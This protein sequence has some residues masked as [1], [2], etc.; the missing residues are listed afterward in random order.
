MGLLTIDLK[1][2]REN[3][4]TLKALADKGCEVGAVVKAESYGLGAAKVSDA[5]YKEGCRTFFIAKAHEIESL[6]DLPADT[7]VIVLN[8]YD[9]DYASLY[10]THQ[11]IPTLGSLY[12]VEAYQSHQDLKHKPCFL[13]FCTEMNRAGLDKDEREAILADPSVLEGLDLKGLMAHFACADEP[14]HPMTE[15]QYETYSAIVP[16]FEEQYDGLE[17]S[18]SNSFGMFRDD[19]YHFDLARP[20]M[21]LY[22]L[23]PTPY[24]KDN[25]MKPVVDLKLSVIRTRLIPKGEFTGYGATYRFEKDTPVALL[26]SGYAD[27]I[28]RTLSNKGKVFWNGIVCPIRGR[29]SMDMIVVDLSDVPEADRPQAGQMMELIGPHQDADALADVAGTIGYEILTSLG[30]RYKRI[31]LD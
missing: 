11:M 14:E 30:D 9:P 7:R 5:L 28:Y 4:R 31:Y 17:R 24:K 12:E 3:Y 15:E 26:S 2:V 21:S 29:V 22:G 27:G 16:A 6:T 18:L 13:K 10:A 23:N 20:G 19:K 8:G 25:P 1:A